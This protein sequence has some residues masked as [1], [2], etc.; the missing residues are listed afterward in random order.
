MEDRRAHCIREVI[1][2]ESA[3]VIQRR[4]RGG[5]DAV[6]RA[7]LIVAEVDLTGYG[8]LRQWLLVELGDL[9]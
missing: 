6:G 7:E 5:S 9:A 3:L 8:S 1:G 2:H 4:T